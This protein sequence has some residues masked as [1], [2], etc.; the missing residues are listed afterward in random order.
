[1]ANTYWI[2]F[3]SPDS[4]PRPI[5]VPAPCQWWCSG[6]QDDKAIICALAISIS[7]DNLWTGLEKYW[8]GLQVSSCEEVASEWK[9]DPAN[10]RFRYKEPSSDSWMPKVL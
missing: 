3:I 1:M 7:E 4:D 2:R 8:P 5:T 9:P 6:Y 10:G